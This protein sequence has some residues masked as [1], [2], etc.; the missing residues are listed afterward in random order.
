MYSSYYQRGVNELK[1]DTKW[2]CAILL[3]K[4][5]SASIKSSD[6]KTLPHR[7]HRERS[8]PWRQR[9]QNRSIDGI[10]TMR[11]TWTDAVSIS[12]AGS[13]ERRLLCS[14][15]SIIWFRFNLFPLV[16]IK[17]GISDRE[18]ILKSFF[19]VMRMDL[20]FWFLLPVRV[21]TNELLMIST[22]E[23]ERLALGIIGFGSEFDNR[24]EF[25]SCAPQHK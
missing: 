2:F 6:L 11:A 25:N 23:S 12:G 24:S 15:A 20:A 9:S 3:F 10:N 17:R 8:S 1:E 5:F 14:P 19:R 18:S 4:L 21:L 16:E 22:R 13:L 7:G